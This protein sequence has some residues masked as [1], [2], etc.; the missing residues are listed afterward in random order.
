MQSRT[1]PR[2]AVAILKLPDPVPAL[3]TYVVGIVTAMTGNPSFPSPAPPMATLKNAID[4][5][6]AAQ[7]RTQSRVRGAA[8]L[9]DEKRAALLS[10]LEQ[11]RA[12]V[13]AQADE[14]PENAPS[15]IESAGMALRKIAA[16]GAPGFHAKPGPVSGSLRIVAPAAGDRASYEWEYSVDAGK[17]WIRMP[18]TLQS[19]TSLSGVAPLTT[20]QVRYRAITKSGE[21]DWSQAISVLVV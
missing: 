10:L 8:A 20:V 9:R 6:Q 19:R 13:Q 15:I 16:A 1:K 17:T 3:I 7:T 14:N 18:A 21:G 5:L 4:D 11:L 2:R 12:Y